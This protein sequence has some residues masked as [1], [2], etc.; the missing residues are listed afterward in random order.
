[1]ALM[2]SSCASLAAAR[3][4]RVSVRVLFVSSWAFLSFNRSADAAEEE[5]GGGRRRKEEEGGG[6]RREEMKR[7]GEEEGR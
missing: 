7:G 3:S 6:R 5:G 4:R 1:M 2:V